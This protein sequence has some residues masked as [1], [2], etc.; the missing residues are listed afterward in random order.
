MNLTTLRERLHTNLIPAHTPHPDADPQH[1]P[2]AVLV[3]VLPGPEGGVLL[4][5]RAAALSAHAGQV[6]FPGGRIDPGDADPE[7][8]ALR[9]AWE[10]IGLDP[11]SVELAGRLPD[12]VTG[13]GFHVVPVVGILAAMPALMLSAAEVDAVFRLS[14][15]VLLDPDAPRHQAVPH[16]G[17]LRDSLVWPHADHLIWGATAGILMELAR[18][19]RA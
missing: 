13:T 1:R 6:S 3:P 2:A 5:R 8:T 12:L 11:V 14:M 10:E 18:C 15:T 16:L 19:L 17:G 7:A 4:T 9:E